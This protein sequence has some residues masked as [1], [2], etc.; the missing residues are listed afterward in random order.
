VTQIPRICQSQFS[1]NAEDERAWKVRPRNRFVPCINDIMLKFACEGHAR[2]TYAQTGPSSG[3]PPSHLSRAPTL[4]TPYLDDQGPFG[5]SGNIQAS[6]F[7]VQI[8]HGREVS[9]G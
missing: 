8:S 5:I 4:R 9:R 1:K 2:A 6:S 3:Y 7:L